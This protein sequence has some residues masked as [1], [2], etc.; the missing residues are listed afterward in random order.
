MLNRI[1]DKKKPK[2][3]PQATLAPIVQE[4]TKLPSLPKEEK[5]DELIK[6]DLT[7]VKQEDLKDKRRSRSRS[8][9]KHTVNRKRRHE[10]NWKKKDHSKDR[11]SNF[12][13]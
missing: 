1:E 8:N 10:Y 7:K 2:T 3:P 4:E 6:T 5:K 11:K 9:D 12:G 13:K